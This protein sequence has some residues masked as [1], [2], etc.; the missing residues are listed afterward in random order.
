M[1][2]LEGEED[3]LQGTGDVEE[4]IDRKFHNELIAKVPGQLIVRGEDTKAGRALFIKVQRANTS[5]ML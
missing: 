3:W 5:S 2:A 1:T 4:L